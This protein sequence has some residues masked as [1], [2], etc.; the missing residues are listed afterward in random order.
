MCLFGLD[1]SQFKALLDDG[2]KIMANN[3]YESEV[4][5]QLG[6][7]IDEA[8]MCERIAVHLISFT[9]SKSNS[10]RFVCL[11]LFS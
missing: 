7:I 10:D 1:L 2:R 5:Q 8:E 11:R 9:N 6:S 3:D 4:V